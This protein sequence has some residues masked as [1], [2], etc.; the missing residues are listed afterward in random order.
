VH[1]DSVERISKA[2]S[3]YPTS[4]SWFQRGYRTTRNFLSANWI[5][6]D[7]DSG[8]TIDEILRIYCDVTH[9]LGTTKSHRI[10]KG[11]QPPC[12]RFRIFLKLPLTIT[13]SSEYKDL[14]RYY[15]E[16]DGADKKCIDSAR[17]FWPCR[18]II[19]AQETD[20]TID[21]KYKPIEFRTADFD[22]G[23][24]RETKSIPPW[25]KHWLEF[26]VPFGEKNTTCFK[27]GSWLTMAGF[28][29]EEI[30]CLIMNST[31]PDKQNQHIER[32]VLNAVN[33][34]RKA[35]IKEKKHQSLG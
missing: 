11:S 14:L 5:G 33:S 12:D 31:I 8:V 13:A 17:F 20:E 32:E 29:V 34:G 10:K 16:K 23:R 27:I 15:V 7:F 9:I 25:V 35:A 26:G 18:E 21:I 1:T 24:Y 30:M 22:S 3:L 19:S 4:P 28:S 2:V 6:L